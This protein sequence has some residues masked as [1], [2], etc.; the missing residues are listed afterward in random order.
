MPPDLKLQRAGPALGIPNFM[1]KAAQNLA[2]EPAM[3]DMR[4]K[5]ECKWR[6]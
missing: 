3:I 6:Q 2:R 4:H 5:G 1:C